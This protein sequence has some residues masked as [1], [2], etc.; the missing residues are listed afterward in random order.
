MNADRHT[1]STQTLVCP[2]RPKEKQTNT[3]KHGHT[4]AETNLYNH[5]STSLIPRSE[6]SLN[7]RVLQRKELPDCCVLTLKHSL[8]VMCRSPKEPSHNAS[9]VLRG[10]GQGMIHKHHHHLWSTKSTRL[11]SVSVSTGLRPGWL[12]V[13]LLITFVASFSRRRARVE[14]CALKVIQLALRLLIRSVSLRE[15]FESLSKVI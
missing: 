12:T 6:P 7:C 10:N 14:P 1:D 11:K 4:H 3:H 5:W 13:M 2:H 8:T 9:S 15:A